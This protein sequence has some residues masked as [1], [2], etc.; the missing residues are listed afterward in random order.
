[1]EYEVWGLGRYAMRG[2]LLSLG[3]LNRQDAEEWA[4]TYFESV[5]VITP[6]WEG[7]GSGR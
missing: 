7:Q 5:I 1:M 4:E 3:F 6:I 2:K